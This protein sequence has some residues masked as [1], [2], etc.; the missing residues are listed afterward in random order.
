MEKHLPGYE[1]NYATPEVHEGCGTDRYSETSTAQKAHDVSPHLPCHT[2]TTHHTKH[3]S[4][5]YTAGASVPTATQERAH[6]AAWGHSI[7]IPISPTSTA[8]MSET[9]YP[10]RS[11]ELRSIPSQ[12]SRRQKTPPALPG[13]ISSRQTKTESF[14]NYSAAASSRKEPTCR[15]AS[16]KPRQRSFASHVKASIWGLFCKPRID[17]DVERIEDRHWTDQ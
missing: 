6:M 5:T 13:T 14:L 1:S 8:T 4:K 17:Y 12:E 3:D 7:G 10:S 16:A 2:F 9:R 15:K 11:H